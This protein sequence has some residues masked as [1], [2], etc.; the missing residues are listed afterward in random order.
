MQ[1]G[2]GRNDTNVVQSQE[3]FAYTFRIG[4][5]YGTLAACT[6]FPGAS[7]KVPQLPSIC[8]M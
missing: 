5:G 3:P 2:V 8:V 6:D 4:N 7:S 1:R